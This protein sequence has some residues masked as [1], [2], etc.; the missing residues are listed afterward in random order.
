MRT[1]DLSVHAF[2]FDVLPQ[3]GIVVDYRAFGR[4][5]EHLGQ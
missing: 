5:F 2:D 1:G 4:S 3:F